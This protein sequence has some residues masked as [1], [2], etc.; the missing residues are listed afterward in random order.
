MITN[1]YGERFMKKCTYCGRDIVLVR[2]EVDTWKSYEL[3]TGN[4]EH[5]CGA[6]KIK[7]V[8]STLDVF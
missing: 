5:N 8:Q 7:T 6:V 3:G 4:G 2:V 1:H